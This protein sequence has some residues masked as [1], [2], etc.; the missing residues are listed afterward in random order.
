MRAVPSGWE[1]EALEGIDC[2]LDPSED[3]ERLFSTILDLCGDEALVVRQGAG[4]K[5]YDLA[6]ADYSEI[7]RLD[8]K[9]A[10]AL[11]NR[12]EIYL[13]KGDHDHAISDFDEALKIK[14]ELDSIDDLRQKAFKNKKNVSNGH[15]I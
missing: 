1:L 11:G 10:E 9:C 3:L 12:G 15:C 4:N 13:A 8:P 2:I 6:I 5:K 14:P 7:I